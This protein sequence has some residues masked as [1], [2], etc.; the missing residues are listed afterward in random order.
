M[1]LRPLLPAIL[2]LYA[3]AADAAPRDRQIEARRPTLEIAGHTIIGKPTAPI[4]VRY[5]L[6]GAP[7]L[8]QP[9]SV[10]IYAEP[11][12]GVTDLTLTLT[13]D[14][15]LHVGPVAQ[16]GS[17][18]GAEQIWTVTVTP[19]RDGVGHVHVSVTGM[20]DGT[21]QTRSLLI[22]VRTSGGAPSSGPEVDRNGDGEAVISLPAEERRSR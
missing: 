18:A 17:G 21:E 10:R 20:V 16:V 5:E 12:P 11:A 7:S 13:A 2:F 6:G 14:E 8:G 22:P 19:V 9:L 1:S 4:A 3:L 15:A